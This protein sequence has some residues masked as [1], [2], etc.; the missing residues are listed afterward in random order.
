MEV[1]LSNADDCFVGVGSGRASF[2]GGGLFG[3]GGDDLMCAG[4]SDD[5]RFYGAPCCPP[6]RVRDALFVCLCI[7]AS[8]LRHAA[9][10]RWLL[11]AGGD[12]HD[13]MHG[14]D[15]NE[16]RFY[17]GDGDD[18]LHPGE[19]GDWGFFG[20]RPPPSARPRRAPAAAPS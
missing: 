17:G 19:G 3:G 15:G 12:G 1:H 18:A 9:A 2:W 10:A 4:D 8:H 5:Y 16:L 14:G 13:T 7:S 11:R 6:R 20:A